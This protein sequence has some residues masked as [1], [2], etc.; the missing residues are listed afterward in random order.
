MRSECRWSN[1]ADGQ[2]WAKKALKLPDWIE[3][4][5]VQIAVCVC[6]ADSS[7][8]FQSQLQKTPAYT[9]D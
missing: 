4:E 3:N 9:S 5:Q 6:I 2:L 1:F 7:F 8:V